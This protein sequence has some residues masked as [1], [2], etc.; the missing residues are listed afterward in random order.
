MVISLVP[1]R[2]GQMVRMRVVSV[3]R[4]VSWE[5]S[6]KQNYGIDF[7]L[8]NQKLS[9]SVDYFL[10]KRTKHPGTV[11]YRPRHSCYGITGLEFR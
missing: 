4:G 6:A 9:G 3:I 1:G 8:F 10:E 11:Q 7:T 2:V 5:K